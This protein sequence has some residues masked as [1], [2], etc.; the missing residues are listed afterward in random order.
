MPRYNS[1]SR[2]H[3]DTRPTVETDITHTRKAAKIA[4][5]AREQRMSGDCLDGYYEPL[6]FSMPAGCTET[7]PDRKT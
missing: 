6:A 3:L 1:D 7:F 2:P 4:D 5:R